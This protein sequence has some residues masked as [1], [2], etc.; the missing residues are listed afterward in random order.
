MFD[1]Y[2]QHRNVV[3]IG[4]LKS[5]PPT[6]DWVTIGVVVS[7]SAKMS[8]KGASYTIWKVSD[9]T[10]E[11]SILLFLFGGAHHE[12][13]KA[14]P[15][16]IV[17]LLNPQLSENKERRDDGTPAFSISNEAQ[18]KK[19]GKSRDFGI[20]A[21][22]RLD[23]QV[24]EKEPRKKSPILWS[25]ETKRDLLTCAAGLRQEPTIPQK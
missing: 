4:R 7:T 24:R 18:I 17:A 5:G 19:M 6:G 9:L 12:F 21:S 16:E 1:S 14:F 22:L 13:W 10:R 20:C 2:M 15:G 3:K 25:R 11:G 23:G 8:S